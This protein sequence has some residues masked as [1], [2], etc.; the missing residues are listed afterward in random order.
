MNRKFS[1]LAKTVVFITCIT[2]FISS[3]EKDE[4]ELIAT[5]MELVSGGSQTTEAERDLG[6]QIEIIV[7]DQNGNGFADAMIYFAV[8]EGSVSVASATTDLDGKASVNWTLGSTVEVQILT[9][10]AFKADGITALTGSPLIVRATAQKKQPAIGDFYAGGVIFYLNYNGG[11]LVCAVSDQSIGAIWGCY[12]T[13]IAGANGVFIGTG[14][15]NTVD[16]EAE[17]T[18]AG[19]AADICANLTLNG[20]NDWFLPSKDELNEIY[21][22]KDVINITAINNGGS[23][24]PSRWYWSST[25][26]GGL[27]AWLQDFTDGSQDWFTKAY[28]LC[29]RAVRAF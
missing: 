23:A 12:E 11:G 5:S 17:C 18:T 1:C 29:V 22:N 2:V 15:Q 20:Y 27:V 25:Q 19:T 4:V 16:I 10:T 13:E 14:A 3:C 9:V 28:T 24:F 26:D 7:K 6:N 21:K 8:S